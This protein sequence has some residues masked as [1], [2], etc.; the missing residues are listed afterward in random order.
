MENITSVECKE[1]NL[2][3]D[4][5]G[6]VF[7]DFICYDANQATIIFL[8]PIYEQINQI[9]RNT[10]LTEDFLKRLEYKLNLT[11]RV[12]PAKL[13]FVHQNDEWSLQTPLCEIYEPVTLTPDCIKM[14]DKPLTI[15]GRV[16]NLFSHNSKIFLVCL[17]KEIDTKS[18]DFV[19]KV[20][21]ITI[22]EEVNSIYNDNEAKK[23]FR[24]ILNIKF[25]HKK[26]F[27]DALARHLEGKILAIEYDEH[28]EYSL[29]TF[30]Y[31]FIVADE[32][33]N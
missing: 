33:R 27:L 2:V 13:T 18:N 9:Y 4:C 1:I 5:C 28:N 32:G 14:G 17:I 26:A 10:K 29:W 15:D 21:T 24:D 20:M 22:T 16:V 6:R 23:K 25:K 12:K 3:L 19:E 31:D 11:L 7:G 8:V 30:I